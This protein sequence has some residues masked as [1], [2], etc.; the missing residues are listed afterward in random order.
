[1]HSRMEKA[2]TH[3]KVTVPN[4]RQRV[5]ILLSSI[6]SQ[7]TDI[8]AHV[9][10]IKGD[11]NGMGA[12]FELTA[13]HFLRADPVEKNKT[14]SKNRNGGPSISSTLGGK[15]LKL[16]SNI[17]GIKEMSSASYQESNKMNYVH[18]DLVL[19]AKLIFRKLRKNIRARK[20]RPEA[21]ATNSKDGG[22]NRKPSR[23]LRI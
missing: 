7:H 10:T 15:A 21:R 5:L 17:D 1:M 6:D 14:K 23:K 3:I 11:P 2:A 4:E 12:D 19:K 13:E 18:G 22:I 20:E 16:E 9:S 8:S